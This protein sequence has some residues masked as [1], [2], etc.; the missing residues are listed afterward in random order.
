MITVEFLT[1]TRV[2]AQ[3]IFYSLYGDKI[4]NLQCYQDNNCLVWYVQGERHI[5]YIKFEIKDK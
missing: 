5:C 2:E 1:R 3:G 4:I